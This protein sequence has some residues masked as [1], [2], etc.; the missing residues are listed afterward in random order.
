MEKDQKIV[1]IQKTEIKNFGKPFII[2]EIGSNHN[3]DLALAKKL[4]DKAVECGADCAKFQAFDTELFSETCYENHP[5]RGE[6]AKEKELDHMFKKIHPELKREIKEYMFSKENLRAIKKYCDKKNIF[7]LCTPLTKELVDFCVD[8]LRMK[9]I[10]VASMDLNNIPFLQY[11]AKKKVPIILSTGMGAF[12]EIATAVQ[13]IRNAGNNDIILLHCVAMY[14]PKNEDIHLRNI[15]LLRNAFQLPV[16]F[17][18]HT[19]GYGIPLASVAM[20]ACIVEKHFTLDKNMPGWDHKISAN[21]EELKI[22][23]SECNKIYEAMGNY[24]RTVSE[25]ELKKRKVFRRSIVFK[26]GMSKGNILKKEDIDFKRPGTG[27][28]PKFWNFII[29]RTLKRDITADEVIQTDDFI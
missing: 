8:D 9:C 5:L 29:G 4:V 16:G 26:K 1:K 6:M 14:P 12:D 22:I 3:G 10:K 20:G 19:A 25:A 2:A 11:I 7:F 13:T 28:E 27:I 23:V 17:S 18:D 21:P 24:H 15:E